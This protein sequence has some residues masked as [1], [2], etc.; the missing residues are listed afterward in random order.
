MLRFDWISKWS[1]YSSEKMAIKEFETSRSLT[2]NQLNNL[3]NRFATKMV[4]EFGLK[5]GDRVAILAENCLEFFILFFTAQKTGIIL[6][7]LNYRLTSPEIDGLLKDFRPALIVVQEKYKATLEKCTT[8]RSIPHCWLLEEVQDFGYPNRNEPAAFAARTEISEDD[9]IFILY[10]AGTTGTPKGSLYTHK[11][12]VWNSIN[13]TMRLDIVSDDRSVSCTPLFHTGGWNVIPTPFLHRGAYFCLTQKFDPDVILQLLADEQATMF[14]AVPTMLRMM[15]QSPLFE[16]V[17]LKRMRFFI[18]GGEPMP[19]PLIDIWHR[20]GIPIRQGFGMTEAGP[21]ITSLHQDY[22]ISKMGSIGLPNFY[23]DARIVNEDGED[24]K[25]NEVGELILRGPSVT[26]GYWNDPETTQRTIKDGWLYTGDLVKQDADGFLYVVDRK[27][28]MYISGG[29][30]VYPAEVEKVLYSHPEIAE[31][32]I[33]GVPDKKWGEVGKAFVV[34][35]P[36]LRL[37]ETDVIEFCKGKLANY[38]IPKTVQ[39]LDK[40]PK[41]E[42]GKIDRKQLLQIHQSTIH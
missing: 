9:P 37:S 24:V 18:I 29:E 2:Y 11:M 23:V 19:L 10:T 36:N 42:T 35:K 34:C 33:I 13:T 27:K 16:K 5:K 8:Y 7:P 6:V 25:V 26:P 31:V 28:F 41:S 12:L 22:A 20:K 15:A 3:A 21:S 38:K 1:Q 32:A 14:M 4:K 40:L 39:F 17:D 30:N